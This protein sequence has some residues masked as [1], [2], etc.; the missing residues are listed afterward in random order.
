MYF[1]PR[2]DEHQSEYLVPSDERI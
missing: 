1:L 2:T